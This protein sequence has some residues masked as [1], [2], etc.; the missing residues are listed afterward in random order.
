MEI[1]VLAQTTHGQII[2]YGGH[3]LL[4]VFRTVLLVDE[5]SPDAVENVR[6]DYKLYLLQ[7]S[8]GEVALKL[9]SILGVNHSKLLCSGMQV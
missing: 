6:N 7:S 1:F 9:S 4:V 8:G 5:G 2:N 3:V